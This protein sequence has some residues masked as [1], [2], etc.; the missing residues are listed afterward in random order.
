MLRNVLIGP[1][2][3][4]AISDLYWGKKKLDLNVIMILSVIWIHHPKRT[5]IKKILNDLKNACVEMF[6]GT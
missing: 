6:S 2:E 5:V 3:D 4:W 1:L